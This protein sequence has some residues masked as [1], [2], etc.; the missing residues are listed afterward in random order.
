MVPARTL[1][2]PIARQVLEYPFVLLRVKTRAESRD[3]VCA[4][5]RRRLRWRSL[6]PVLRR[7]SRGGGCM[8]CIARGVVSSIGR[9]EIKREG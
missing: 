5:G 9:V 1:A 7:H 8:G 3:T 4:V 6:T 2:N